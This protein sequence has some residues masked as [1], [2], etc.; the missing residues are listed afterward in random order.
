MQFPD[1]IRQDIKTFWGIPIGKM[2][3]V[4]VPLGLVLAGYIL[5]FPFPDITWRIGVAIGIFLII[6]G[7]MALN[8][9]RY[10]GIYKRYRKRLKLFPD[11]PGAKSSEQNLTCLQDLIRADML[12]YREDK[13]LIEW[14]NGWISVLCSVQ[15][16]P[17]DYES[18][19]TVALIQKGLK[20]ALAVASANHLNLR[21]IDDADFE[22]DEAFWQD[23]R[24]QALMSIVL[25]GGRALTLD[26]MATYEN[27]A[28]VG[29]VS[30]QLFLRIDAS[31]SQL[32]RNETGET[33]LK[34]K[35]L[36][37]ESFSYTVSSF[38][39]VMLRAQLT[40][41]PLGEEDLL[42]IIQRDLAPW[43]RGKLTE[44]FDEREA[45]MGK[46]HEI[47]GENC[48]D[49]EIKIKIYYFSYNDRSL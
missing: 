29:A 28:K 11:K 39:D 31:L 1:D 8:L 25:P 21:W 34:R 48:S 23:R 36:A 42:W 2:L 43:I 18:P 7:C 13:V 14:D 20:D 4:L 12:H 9:P 40:L 30:N 33:D 6:A 32:M 44:A 45:A 27:F 47:N 38:M 3:K 26:R 24:E 16:E 19:A 49:K 37:L 17:I 5:W 46:P 41:S 15:T 22:Y 10:F 35:E